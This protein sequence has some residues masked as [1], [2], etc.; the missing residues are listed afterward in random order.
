MSKLNFEK[1]VFN[2]VPIYLLE[3]QFS[4]RPHDDLNWHEDIEIIYIINGEGAIIYG[5]ETLSLKK[6]I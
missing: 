1:K 2:K 5:S 3:M 4:I 6:R